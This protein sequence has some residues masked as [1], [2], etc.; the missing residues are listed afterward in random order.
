MNRK[1][2]RGIAEHSDSYRF[3][4]NHIVVGEYFPST[5]TV[6]FLREHVYKIGRILFLRNIKYEDVRVKGMNLV[7]AVL[8]KDYTIDMFMKD[9]GLSYVS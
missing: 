9:T 1:L 7:R 6:Y 2:I 8:T 3:T 5:Y 4:F